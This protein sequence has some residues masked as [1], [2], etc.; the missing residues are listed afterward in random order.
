MKQ[1]TRSARPLKTIALAG[2]AAS[3]ALTISGV[4]A[5]GPLKPVS[6]VKDPI[7]SPSYIQNGKLR[8]NAPFL[9][10]R[11][12]KAGG[13]YTLNPICKGT[14][15]A[16]YMGHP[17][18]ANSKWR[19]KCPANGEVINNPTY[20]TTETKAYAAQRGHISALSLRFKFGSNTRVLCYGILSDGQQV[21][22]LMVPTQPGQMA[23]KCYIKVM[24][25]SVGVTNWGVFKF[26]HNPALPGANAW[27]SPGS[28]TPS[29]SDLPMYL[30]TRDNKE[31]CRGKDGI[32]SFAGFLERTNGQYVCRAP[33]LNGLQG[34][35]TFDLY[36][37]SKNPRP[38]WSS[39]WLNGAS[40][41]W[42]RGL[43][44]SDGSEPYQRVYLCKQSANRDKIG[45]V[46]E[47]DKLCKVPGVSSA[48]A[49]NSYQIMW[50]Y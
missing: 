30:Y 48:A 39:N 23:D 20:Y 47:N 5:A 22:G 19:V 50:R 42:S 40:Q 6:W 2:L 27:W 7:V 36:Y 13:G 35:T 43:R 12:P 28:I 21:P 14:D 9:G 41:A 4:A 46:R 45:Y 11:T 29:T 49:E 34:F 16:I 3:A 24:G 38:R 33:T 32:Y 10:I 26:K 37:A 18:Y 1:L 31:L 15:N 44:V 8:D 17:E 25:S